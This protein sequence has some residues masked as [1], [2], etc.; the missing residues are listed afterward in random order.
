MT[1][2]QEETIKLENQIQEN[3]RN[4]EP[5]KRRP[6]KKRPRNR[7]NK[8]IN[9][10]C[11]NVR[12]AKGKMRSM[13][14]LVEAENLHITLI[15][16]TMFKGDEKYNIKGQKWV[17]RNRKNKTGGGVGILVSEKISNNTTEVTDIEEDEDLETTWVKID[18]RPDDVY[19]GV[20][21]GPQENN[22]I[23]NTR[24]IYNKLETQIK[25]LQKRG[26]VIIGG[27][28][29]AKLKITSEK[30][31]QEESRNGMLLQ[32]IINETHL[33]PITIEPDIGHWTRTN[34][35]NTSEKSIIDYILMTEKLTTKRGVTI[36]DETGQ[37]R[38]KGKNE[39][40]HNTIT[41]SIKINDRRTPKYIERWKT[42][43]NEQ[44]AEYNKRIGEYMKSADL[45]ST[46]YSKNEE[47]IRKILKQTI[48]KTKIRTDKPN[49][50][51][52]KTTKAIGKMKK[53]KKKEFHEE[54]K[55]TEEPNNKLQKKN[56][57][58]KLQK[59]LR[60]AIEEEEKIRTEENM[61]K[62]AHNATINKNT[63][64][65]IRKRTKMN[66]QLDYN[67]ITE[68]GTT[69][70]DP[71]ETKEYIRKW[72]EELYQARP[73][74]PEYQEW[75]EKIENKVKEI[76]RDYDKNK[77]SQGSEEI[78]MKEL[79]NAIKK[80][81]T[82]KSTGPDDIPN[83]TFIKANHKTK[84]MYLKILNDIHKTEEIPETWKK[85]NI[86]RLY[87]GKGTKGKCSNERGITLASNIGK[88]YERIINNR[89]KPLVQITQAQ[90]GGIEGNATVDHLITLKDAISE[91]H[92]QKKTAYVIFLD[93]KKAYDKA[94]LDAILYV[95]DKNGIK[96]KNWEM[97]RLMNTEL[98]AS[99]MTRF[100][101]TDEITIKDSIRQGGV[102]SVI[103]YALMI[104]EISKE[105]TSQDL[106]IEVNNNKMGCL[107]WMDDIALIH[108]DRKIL[109]KMMDCTNN[110][111]KRYHI[112]FGAEKCKIVKI[113]RGKSADIILNSTKLEESTKYKYL[114]EIINNRANL[115][116]HIQELKGKT[117]AAVQ[118][119]Y[120]ETGNKEFKGIKMQ[121]IWQL[122]E[123]SIIPIITYASESW[124]PTKKELEEIQTIFNKILREVLRIPDST[125]TTILL[126]ETGFL[127]IEKI[128]EKKRI[129]Q[130]LRI[131]KM[132][133]EKFIKK[134]TRENQ[135]N[136]KKRTDE[137]LKK[138]NVPINDN[139]TET[140]KLVEEKMTQEIKREIHQEAE[141]KSKVRHWIDRI[142]EIKPGTRPEYMNKLNRKQCTAIIKIRSRMIPAKENMKGT[143]KDTTCRWCKKNPETQEH[144]ID[145]CT[146]FKQKAQ[147]Q[148]LTYQSIY[149]NQDKERM[150]NIANQI[151]NIIE[152]LE[153]HQNSIG[154]P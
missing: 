12:G 32:A 14:S 67:T 104:D 77:E 75:T 45:S 127:P 80:L 10:A 153:N 101:P 110:I 125:P 139:K 61:K 97:I 66:N 78:T 60:Q 117:Q 49:K 89:I 82:K 55:K 35:N 138:Y 64:W 13:Q 50:R 26:E 146:E 11:I 16:E 70:E 2:T 29:N 42:G 25:Q 124:N 8:E 99:I 46:N 27:D 86:K 141:T 149:T 111:A 56:E 22:P 44:W 90:A 102:L 94:W 4:E 150:A 113:G 84:D 96:G 152:T 85:G 28:F 135:S 154:S 95:L 53:Q 131:Q 81:K 38:I 69:L 106:G 23:E 91:I 107:L 65:Q 71:T 142:S 148:D 3:P 120:M 105:L 37:L 39:T 144:L 33:N 147:I 121:A 36:I 134:I 73:G 93:V 47:E 57:Y 72:Y 41:T 18:T 116:D 58:I 129:M 92:K 24:K 123:A 88:V 34:R 126:Q 54:C 100:G 59:E 5:N 79:N 87:K 63:I 145:Q 30:G 68:E 140:K 9:I 7:K 1:Q 62:L 83:E 136:W 109:Q 108:Y 74:T 103:E 15:T 119:I 118:K 133:E 48:G 112:E 17:G 52:T 20:F 40:D 51:T 151:I 6:K 143:Y 21:Y 31:N 137:L 122:I 114:G 19:I 98:R 132:N 76:R 128:I 130:N 43:T 115:K